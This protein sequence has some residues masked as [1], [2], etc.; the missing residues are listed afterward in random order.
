M[1]IKESRPEE[2]LFEMRRMTWKD[3]NRRLFLGHVD[4]ASLPDLFI[5][6]N[7]DLG[8][9]KEIRDEYSR[10][11]RLDTTRGDP[12]HISVHAYFCSDVGVECMGG[13]PLCAIHQ[14]LWSDFAAPVRLPSDAPGIG[15]QQCCCRQIVPQFNLNVLIA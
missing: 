1:R 14:E 13:I 7:Q 3:L 11:R 8:P 15:I 12:G 5:Q 6:S 4:R 10:H 9:V 2:R